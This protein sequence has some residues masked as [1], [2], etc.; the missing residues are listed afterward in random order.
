MEYKS[1]IFDFNGTLLFDSDFHHQAWKQLVKERLQLE[2]TE[3]EMNNFI[4]GLPNV[5]A[6]EKL[7]PNKY[8]LS[9]KEQLSKYKEELYRNIITNTPNIKLVDGAEKLFNILNSKNIPF[10]IASASIIENIEF[11][12]TTFNLN[13]WLKLEDIIYDNGKYINK[14]DMFNDALA[15]LN[16]EKESC[17][18]F[19]DS[20]SGVTSAIEAGFKNIILLHQKEYRDEFKSIPEIIYHSNN[21]KDIFTFLL[22]N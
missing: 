3:N 13:N 11:F 1:V 21:F 19:E 4:H 9:E 8:T 10:T 5:E 16:S 20:L 6:I 18:I 7:A 15:I 22:N 2:L 12:Y 17:L 14:V